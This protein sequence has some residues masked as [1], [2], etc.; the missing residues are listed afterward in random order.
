MVNI[1]G[2]PEQL[3]DAG[4]A[5]RKTIENLYLDPSGFDLWSDED[6]II[7]RRKVDGNLTCVRGEC[8]IPAPL[9]ETFRFFIDSTKYDAF[10]PVVFTAD[11]VHKYSSTAWARVVQFQRVLILIFA[12]FITSPKICPLTIF[13]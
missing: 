12:E 9:I 10:N 8:I 4:I 13:T 3:K 6:G 1:E 11:V 7:S 5:A 2:L